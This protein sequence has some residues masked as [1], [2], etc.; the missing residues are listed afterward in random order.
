MLN[1]LRSKTPAV[2][3]TR[4][5]TLNAPHDDGE[6]AFID[7][8]RGRTRQLTLGERK[9]V[10]EIA[11][12][13]PNIDLEIYFEY[14]SSEITPEA[15]PDLM[16]LGRVLTSADL[17]GNVF[18][19]GGHTDAKGSNA[20]NQ[21]LSER[22]AASVKQFLQENFEIPNAA[23]VT[24]GFGEE[25]LKNVADPYAAENRRVQIVNLENKETAQR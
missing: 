17:K 19:I 8:I 1:A 12:T 16:K 9:K 13:K 3:K 5:L 24:T 2:P 4:G 21:G 20:Y 14:N 10:A 15:Q 6:R 22:R 23:L 11:K 25:Q 7:S 18:L